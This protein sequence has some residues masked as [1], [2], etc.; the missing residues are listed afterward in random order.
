MDAVVSFP[1]NREICSVVDF[2]ASKTYPAH[3]RGHSADCGATAAE[4]RE[5]ASE[6]GDC[7]LGDEAFEPGDLLAWRLVICARPV[8]EARV[9]RG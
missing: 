8:L 1:R 6:V 3:L 5:F 4:L 9:H 7:R 2:G